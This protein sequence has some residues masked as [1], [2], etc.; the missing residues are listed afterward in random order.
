M[1]INDL[2]DQKVIHK[3]FGKGKVCAVD[4]ERY[5]N[6]KF[7]QKAEVCKFVYPQ[8][9]YGYLMLENSTFQSQII[10]VIEN[11]KMEN[12]IEEKEKLRYKYNETLR[13]IEKRRTAAETK[14]MRASQRMVE[15]R[16]MYNMKKVTNNNQ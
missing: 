10:S 6:V 16:T 14:K 4:N 12:R 1:E 3:N 7:E 8:C 5:L 2:V 15:H 9:F 11:W 13:S